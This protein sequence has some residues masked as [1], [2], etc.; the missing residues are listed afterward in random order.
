[1]TWRLPIAHVLRIGQHS[2]SGAE[3]MQLIAGADPDKAVAVPS[4]HSSLH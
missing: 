3:V 1:M 4:L 2:W